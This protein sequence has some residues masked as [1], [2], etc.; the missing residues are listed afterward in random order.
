MSN[1]ELFISTYLDMI[2]G[3]FNVNKDQAVD[4]IYADVIIPS[5]A[6]GELM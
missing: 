1:K 2:A 3:K 4:E 5:T 6:D